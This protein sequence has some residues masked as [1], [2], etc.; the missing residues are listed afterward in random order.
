[1]NEDELKELRILIRK[2]LRENSLVP[3]LNLIAKICIGD[4]RQWKL[5]AEFLIETIRRE[6]GELTEDK[7]DG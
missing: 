7:N 1:M 2:Y 5:Y 4:E 6:E 3:L